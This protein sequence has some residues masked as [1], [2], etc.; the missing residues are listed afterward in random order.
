[1]N[2]RVG[3]E[4]D[5]RL[6]PG[7]RGIDDRDPGQHVLLVDAVAE[8]C[9]CA[10]QFDACVHALSLLGIAFVCRHQLTVV[11]EEPHGIGQ[12]ELS[13]SVGRIDPLQRGPELGSGEDVDGRVDLVDRTLLVRRVSRLDDR[14]N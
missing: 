1:M 3:L 13:L 11:D 9:P 10:R 7:R 6:D 8:R 2:R 14:A 12:V 4:L 5:G